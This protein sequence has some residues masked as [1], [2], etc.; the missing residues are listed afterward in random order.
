MSTPFKMK[1]SPFQ[2]NFNIGKTEAPNTESP[3]NK[4]S[5]PTKG[6]ADIDL[7]RALGAG[8]ATLPGGHDAY[9]PSGKKEYERDENGKLIKDADGNYIEKE[10]EENTAY[11]PKDLFGSIKNFLGGTKSAGSKIG[12]TIGG[13]GLKN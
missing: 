8:M 1:G 7:G 4:N 3:Y 11:T 5:T 12:K 2:R 10:Q 6:L 9:N 13:L